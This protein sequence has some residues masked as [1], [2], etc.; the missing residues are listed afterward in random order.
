[1]PG[2]FSP[3]FWPV[4]LTD[5]INNAPK[6]YQMNLTGAFISPFWCVPGP[7]IRAYTAPKGCI[8]QAALRRAGL[9]FLS[10]AARQGLSVLSSW[11]FK[12]SALGMA[13]S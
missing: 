11:E 10:P 5:F 2:K 13:G 1:M 6:K 7:G 9:I 4:F 8:R 12:P 3:V